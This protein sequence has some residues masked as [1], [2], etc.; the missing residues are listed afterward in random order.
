MNFFLENSALLNSKIFCKK[1]KTKERQ[2]ESHHVWCKYMDN[3]HGYTWKE[4]LPNRYYLCFNCHKQLH[5]EI[6]IPLLNKLLQTLKY[7]GHEFW[8]WKQVLQKDKPLIIEEVI[9]A[10]IKFIEGEKNDN[11]ISTI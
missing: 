1:C 10:T 8:L 5:Q 3:P 9:N 7:N 2:M 11:S 6:I 4:G